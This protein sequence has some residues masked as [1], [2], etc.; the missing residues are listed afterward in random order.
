MEG[1]NAN[2]DPT[3]VTE[4]PFLKVRLVEGADAMEAEGAEGTVM[5]VI[6][7]WRERTDRLRHEATDLM[8]RMYPEGRGNGR[9]G[10]GIEIPS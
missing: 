1:E 5:H 6:T 3:V 8:N 9:R 10:S 7:Q 4:Q 2:E